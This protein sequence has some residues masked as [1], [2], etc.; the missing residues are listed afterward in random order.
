MTMTATLADDETYNVEALNQRIL[1]GFRLNGTAT[2]NQVAA[3]LNW[4][5]SRKMKTRVLGRLEALR[6]AGVLE[7]T[8]VGNPVYRVRAGW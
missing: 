4:S 6:G 5:T 1:D 7:R 3:R 8:E 2:A